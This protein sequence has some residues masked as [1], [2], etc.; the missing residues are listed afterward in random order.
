VAVK[1]IFNRIFAGDYKSVFL[2]PKNQLKAYFYE[3]VHRM[4]SLQKFIPTEKLREIGGK[5]ANIAKLEEARKL[6]YKGKQ[7]YLR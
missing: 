2:D 5:H 1:Y 4:K 6:L 3:N 7:S